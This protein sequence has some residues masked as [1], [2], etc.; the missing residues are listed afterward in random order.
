MQPVE[1]EMHSGYIQYNQSNRHL[2]F[3]TESDDHVRIDNNGHL[4]VDY[5]SD[6]NARVQ[7]GFATGIWI[8]G[9]SS[10]NQRFY[11]KPAERIRSGYNGQVVNSAIKIVSAPALTIQSILDLDLIDMM[12]S[13]ATNGTIQTSDSR[14]SKQEVVT[15]VLGIDFIK[16]LRPVSYKWIEGKKVPIVD[17]TDENGDNIYRSD[18]DGNW[19]YGS[20]SR[21]RCAETLDGLSLKRSSRL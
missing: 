9:N 18:A 6:N 1:L 17:G 7:F 12:M 19:V 10:D 15:S 4:E 8:T 14:L 3:G 20:C 11:T 16:A 13:Y 2:T 5:D 21:S